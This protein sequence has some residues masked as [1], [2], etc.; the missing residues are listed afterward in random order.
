MDICKDIMSTRILFSYNNKLGS[1]IIRVASA[2]FDSSGLRYCDI[3]SHTAILMHGTFVVESVMHGGV[4]IIPYDVWKQ[5]N[6]EIA[7]LPVEE[8]KE[9]VVTLISEMWGRKYDFVGLMYFVYAVLASKLF[10]KQIPTQNPFE[11]DNKFFCVE[12]V[13]RCLGIPNYSTTTPAELMVFL[14]RV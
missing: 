4:R 1:K 12:L 14:L 3:P 11:S 13:G 9:P 8:F 5:K 7:S 2:L 6:T 10:K